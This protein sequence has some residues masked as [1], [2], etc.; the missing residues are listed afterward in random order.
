MPSSVFFSYLFYV[1]L[2]LALKEIFFKNEFAP[3]QPKERV[4]LGREMIV[5]LK[6][7]EGE[8]A[9]H[10][11]RCDAVSSQFYFVIRRHA[12]SV[13]VGQLMSLV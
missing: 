4:R 13:S 5:N 12:G 6:I 3:I 2:P 11:A 9:L 7:I 10:L 1:N 8:A